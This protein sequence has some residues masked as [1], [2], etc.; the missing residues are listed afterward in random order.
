[1][2][3]NNLLKHISETGYNVGYSAK[4]HFASFEM[5]E[6]VPGLLS[7]I[8]LA[9]GVYALAF[10]ELS[11]KLASSTLL[12]LGIVGLYIS[13]KNSD[14]SDFKQKGIALTDLFN[15]LKHLMAEVKEN[16]KSAQEASEIL[17][18]IEKRYNT[19]CASHHPM[20]ATWFAHYKFFWEQQTAWIGEYR[21]F[22]FWRDKVPLSL[23][24]TILLIII[25]SVFFFS[26]ITAIICSIPTA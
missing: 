8:S 11:T 20:F 16:T 26:D 2:E 22:S 18:D 19:C 25:G 10:A 6:K 5:I 12:V 7:F 4:L 23:W 1:M 9:F 15:E 17:K 14:K 24:I 3:N 21:P 13:L